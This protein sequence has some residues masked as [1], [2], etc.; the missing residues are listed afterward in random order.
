[1]NVT[2][3]SLALLLLLAPLPA[4]SQTQPAPPPA[5]TETGHDISK[6]DPAP[7]GGAIAIPLP[8]QE[9]KRLR[10]YEIPELV[11]SRQ[12]IG[13][14]LINGEL[15]HPL[16]DYFVTDAG[17]DQRISFFEGNLVVVRMSGAGG[18]IQKRVIIPDDAMKKY[19]EAATPARI[20]KITDNDVSEPRD[21]RRAFLR[22]YGKSEVVE[23]VF[24]PSGSR[25]RPL[26]DAVAPLEDLLRA[27]S[28]DRTVTST[29]AGY[30]P[31]AGDELVGDDRKVWRVER[32]LKDGT[33]QLR[34]ISQ[35]TVVF[36]AKKDLYNYFVGKKQD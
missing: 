32:V 1:M 22:V 21:T 8:E 25:P 20:R 29:V 24:D 16:L 34:C 18:T 5:A 31:K 6:V 35:P 36:V 10:K 23:R 13:S 26:Q 9:Q 2:G 7:L 33:V 17:I 27:I 12:A 28:E 3:R 14:Q 11:G 15:P 4:L 30:E 19:L